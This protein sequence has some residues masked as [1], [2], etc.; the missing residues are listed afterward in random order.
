MPMSGNA[1]ESARKF[2]A[3]SGRLRGWRQHR[4]VRRFFVTEAAVPPSSA[5]AEMEGISSVR[6]SLATRPRGADTEENCSHEITL[7]AGIYSGCRAVCS[8][9]DRNTG[10][11]QG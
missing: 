1:P 3:K 7:F 9:H 4:P 2:P 5:A 11:R 8:V 6:T 10:Q